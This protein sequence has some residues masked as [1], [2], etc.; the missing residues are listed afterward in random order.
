M[1]TLEE[2]RDFFI[3]YSAVNQPWA[4]WI[5]V[6]LERAGYTTMLQ[7]WDFEPGNDFVQRMQQAT[8]TAAR[9]IAVLSPAYFG[10]KFGGAE[11]GSALAQD[12]TGELARLVPVRV[13]PCEPPG[14]LASRVYIDLVGLAETS[15]RQRLLAGVKPD[16]R[17]NSAPFPGMPNDAE[18]DE[19]PDPA[20]QARF[21]GLDPRVSNLSPRNRNF[22]GREA[23]LLALHADLQA[24]AA[25]AVL[26]VG[27]VHGLGG[28]GKTQLALEYAH[29]FRSDYDVIWW[30]PA[31]QPVTAGAALAA[32]A[33]RLGI[34]TAADQA[35]TVAALFDRL[36]ERRRWLLV[37]DN[38]E[39]PDQLIGLLPPGGVG[40]VLVTS[41]WPAWSSHATSLRLDVLS[42]R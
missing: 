15:A 2:G 1:V 34:H 37:Y 10:S 32:L 17:P 5:A 39:Q 33:S 23:L 18:A 35:E 29:R 40:H 36:R 30:V 21:P 16:G 13:Q 4:E 38:A 11:W 27:A 42:Q 7:A 20:G 19:S 31:E 24:D 3:S 25:A 9:T 26:P 28:V 14:L 6:T 41:R 12:P 22:S 8:V